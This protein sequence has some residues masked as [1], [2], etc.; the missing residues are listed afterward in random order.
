MLT[1]GGGALLCMLIWLH[2]HL[3]GCWR[4]LDEEAMVACDRVHDV[5]GSW[6]YIGGVLVVGDVLLDG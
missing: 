5:Q 2:V 1:H 3:T 4:L 6:R